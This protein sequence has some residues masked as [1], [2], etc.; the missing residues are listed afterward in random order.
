VEQTSPPNAGG[1][2]GREEELAVLE[3]LLEGAFAGEGN[4]ALLAGEPGIGKTRTAEEFAATARR[5]GAHTLWGRCYEGDG[6]PAY[7]P[8]VQAIR[9]YIQQSDPGPLRRELGSGAA[10]IAEVVPEVREQLPG[11]RPPAPL[12]PVQARFRFFDSVTRFLRNVAAARPLVLLL[13]DLHRADKPSLLLLEFLAPELRRSRLL[14]VGGYRKAEVGRQHP[15]TATLAELARAQVGERLVLEGL[16]EEDVARLVGSIAGLRVPPSIVAALHRR[17]EGNPFFL[18]Q[19]IRLLASE[20]WL[21]DGERALRDGLPLPPGVR[22]AI[23]QRLDR[24]SP[25]CNHVLGVAAALGREFRLAALARALSLGGEPLLEALEEAV[26]ARIL[27]EVPGAI[28]HYRF[29]HALI[30]EAVYSELGPATRVRLHRRI[31]E[32]LETTYGAELEPH[33]AELAHHFVQ[34]APAGA[35]NKAVAY[36]ERAAERA[37]RLLAHEEAARH[38]EM[39]LGALE[40]VGPP[41]EAQRC[42]LLLGLGEAQNR[43]GDTPQARQTFQRAAGLAR[44]LRA[45]AWLAQ[46]ALGFGGPVVTGG[47]VDRALIDLLE[48]ALTALPPAEGALRARLMARLAMELYYADAPGRK[49]ALSREAVETA[50]QAGDRAALGFALNARR[51]A[52]WGPDNLEERLATATELVQLAD[53]AGDPELALQGYRWR[54]PD[55]LELGDAA[56]ADAD[57]ESCARRAEES[58]QPLYAWYTQV[59]RAQQALLAGRLAEA[60]RLADQALA[61]GQRAQSGSVAIY[62]AA[63]LLLLRREQ[64]RPAEVEPAIR[65]VVDQFRLPLFRCW[66]AQLAAELGREEEAR[67]ALLE[68][69]ADR[70]VGLPRDA[71]WLGGVA[72]LAEACAAL[73]DGG[74]AELLYGALSPY[75]GRVVQVGVPVCLGSA[76]YYLGLLATTLGRWQAAAQHFAAALERHRRLGAPLFAGHTQA[77]EAAMRLSRGRAGDREGALALLA[78]ASQTAGALGSDRLAERARAL[79]RLALRG[80]SAAQFPERGVRRQAAHPDGLTAREVEV[81][82]RLASGSTSKEIAEDLVL[83]VNTVENHLAHI[84]GKIGARGRVDATAYALRHGILVAGAPER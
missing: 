68:L 46:A 10:D 1:F 62:H 58:R 37:A 65:G 14:V 30:P 28:G 71:L 3:A 78:Q 84:Y 51:Y 54:I 81:L 74:V 25:A 56:A 66:L 8:W 52:I 35:A 4:L 9:A 82:R 12:E 41:D 36:A 5:R 47:L 45:P 13:D 67:A 79:E 16:R 34:A 6:A 22:E 32:A 50:R 15:L 17:T 75:A 80:R 33:L 48:E 76:A 60:E 61:V 70:L 21:A 40:L 55:L 24:L 18:T 69:R 44:T 19:V 2:V 29:V 11:L 20:G 26:G 83:S 53:E 59:F 49:F 39:A 31:G 23:A 38:Y 63:Q 73:S 57:L 7:W 42:R 27:A 77:A 64:G 43:A 72:A